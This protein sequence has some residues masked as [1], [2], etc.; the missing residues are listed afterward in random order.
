[1]TSNII[2][3]NS[4][5]NKFKERKKDEEIVINYNINEEHNDNYVVHIRGQQR[6][7]RKSL[8]LISGLPNDLNLRKIVKVLQKIYSTRGAIL[9][10]KDGNCEIIQLQGDHRKDVSE[11]LVKYHVV[12]SMENIK[13]HGF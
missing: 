1:M 10:E 12:H 7:G 6:S 3:A 2:F 11:F 4:D 9:R 5:I 13:I 8:T